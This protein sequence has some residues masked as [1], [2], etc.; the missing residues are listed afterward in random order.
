MKSSGAIL[1]IVLLP[2]AVTGLTCR[3]YFGV[4]SAKDQTIPTTACTSENIRQPGIDCAASTTACPL[5]AASC[6]KEYSCD[7]ATT[8]CYTDYVQINGVYELY[9]LCAESSNYF[10]LARGGC[11]E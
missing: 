6:Y 10:G 4:S 9:G 7:S 8:E 1:T 5:S 2:L 11:N 3:F